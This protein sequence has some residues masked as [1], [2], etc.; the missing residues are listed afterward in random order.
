MKIHHHHAAQRALLFLLFALGLCT[1]ARAEDRDAMPSSQQAIERSSNRTTCY[2]QFSG[3]GRTL[4]T[5]SATGKPQPIVVSNDQ[6]TDNHLKWTVTLNGNTAKLKNGVGQ[7]L[8]YMSDG[9]FAT[10]L[11]ETEA[12]TFGWTTNSYYAA[13][14]FERYQLL[15]PGETT[16][17]VGVRSGVLTTVAANSRYAVVLLAQEVKGA[18]RCLRWK[19]PRAPPTII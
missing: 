10:T 9:T 11:N 15:L 13:E 18:P 6:P 19:L 7:W 16:R 5:T 2:V 17:A 4:L 1:I 8:A 3:V 14:G 12:T